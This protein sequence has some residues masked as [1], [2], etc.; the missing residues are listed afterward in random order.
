[1]THPRTPARRRRRPLTLASGATLGALVLGPAAHAIELAVEGPTVE[2]A[3][4]TALG[5]RAPEVGDELYIRCRLA[6]QG[7]DPPGTVRFVFRV[8]GTVIR[9]LS[10]PVTVGAPVAIGEYWKPATPGPHEVACEAGP[11]RKGEEALHTANVRSRTVEVRPRE[12]GP[13]PAAPSPPAPR[14]VAP[15]PP[16]APPGGPSAPAPPTAAAPPAPT[17]PGTAPAGPG[18]PDLA[19]VAVTTVGDP[20]CG[21]KE[22]SV[23]ARVTVKNVS[24][25]AFVPSRNPAMLETTVKI[26]NQ[27]ALGGRK[28]LPRLEPGAVAELEVTARNRLPI[29][30]A[31]GLRYSVVIIVNGESKVEEV[32]LDNNGEYVKAVFPRC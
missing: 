32:T 12:S 28:A 29:P 11:E 24:E 8:D 6:A 13:A 26:A 30:D 14:P 4:G 1:L 3:R 27:T 5:N 17:A 22:P 15:A 20:G 9:E 19:I 21:P 23:T 10:V 25:A 31:G 16:T 2:D 18:K 7:A